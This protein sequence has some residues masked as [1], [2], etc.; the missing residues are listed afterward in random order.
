[1]N[2]LVISN[3]T[4]G[5]QT[6]RPDFEVN[7]DSFPVLT[8][9][10]AWRGRIKKK[11]GTVTLGR[12]RYDEVSQTLGN[13][14]GGGGFSGNIFALITYSTIFTST[15]ATYFPNS[16]IVPSSLSIVIGASTFTDTSPPTGVLT[17]SAGGTGTINYQTGDLTITGAS[18]ATPVV[19]TFSFYPAL[20][21]LGIEDF[22]TTIIDFPTTVFFDQELSYAFDDTTSKFHSVN[23]YK[24]SGKPFLWTGA[25]YQQFWTRNYQGAMFTT[26]GRPGFHKMTIAGVVVGPPAVVNI[27]GHGLI[28]GDIIFINEVN[29]NTGINLIAWTVTFVDANHVS[30]NNSGGVGGAYVNGGIAIYLTSNTPGGTDGDGIKWYDG[31]FTVDNTT[32]WVNFVPPLDNTATPFYLIGAKMILPFK[33]RLLMFNTTIQRSSGAAQDGPNL[34]IYSQDGTP[35]YSSL[36]PKN[37]SGIGFNIEAWYQ[38]VAGFGG[39][40]GAPIP[41]TIVLVQENED[42]LIVKFENRDLKILFTGDDS[43]PFIYQTINVEFGAQSRFSGINLDTGCFSVGVYGLTLTTPYSDQRV[44]LI[45]PDQVFSISEA[46][47]GSDRVTAVRDYRN[48]YVYVSYPSITDDDDTS[49]SDIFNNQTLLWNYRDNTWAIFNENYTHYGT[50]RRSVNYTW[51]TLPFSSWIEWTVPWNFGALAER[52]PSIAAGNQQGFVM[53]RDLGSTE[54]N[55]QYIQNITADTTGCIITSPNH[56][57]EDDDFITISGVIGTNF[58]ALNNTIQKISRSDRNTFKIETGIASG[59]YIGGG[60]YNRITIYDIRT[61]AFP[62]FWENGRQARIGTQMFLFQNAPTGE[63]TVNIYVN[64]IDDYSSNDPFADPFLV[65]SNVVLTGPEPDKPIQINQNQIWHRSSNSFNGDSVQIGFTLSDAQ[66]RIPDIN[67][68][69]FVLYTIAIDLY[70]GPILA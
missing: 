32:G 38:N 34:L 45:I 27:N 42:V 9:A 61:K 10:Y 33:G 37:T 65:S 48:E 52:Y 22:Q 49:D 13:T 60:V 50:Y 7:N 44:D 62:I 17:G 6:N 18:A 67:R 31:D 66:A 46:N 39:R 11:S 1:M 30:L 15:L 4:S 35:Y 70:P 21:V 58:T 43:L 16:S 40:I 64:Q 5:L 20:P 8:N 23:Y 51:A 41:Q 2:K 57:L 14:S 28:T 36:V 55:S 68:A 54:G 12:L 24:S 59:T 25:D 63:T 69:E 3:V 53:L 47:N 56:N 19:V 29:G 26:N